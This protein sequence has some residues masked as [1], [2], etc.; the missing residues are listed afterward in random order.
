MNTIDEHNKDTTPQK[1]SEATEIQPKS[2]GPDYKELYLRLQAD[3]Q[4]MKRRT[5]KERLEWTGTIQAD[6]LEK[7][8]PFIEDL[9]RALETARTN[10][11]EQTQA[12]LEGFELIAKNL[13]KTFSSL[14]VEEIVATGQFNPELHEALTHVQSPEHTSGTII[15]QLSK[16]FMFKG[17]VIK[18]ARVSVAQ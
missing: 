16:G 11:T 17:K 1:E 13:K 6:L 4:N 9:D 15:T 18:H 14:G 8:I 2:Q 5:D 10:K 7:F 12:W 3:L